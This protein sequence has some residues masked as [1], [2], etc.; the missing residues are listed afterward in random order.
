MVLIQSVKYYNYQN[1]SERTNAHSGLSLI[2]LKQGISTKNDSS[3]SFR[4]QK[5]E[6]KELKL[7]DKESGV[8]EILLNY[9][10]FFWKRSETNIQLKATKELQQITHLLFTYYIHEKLNY[11][12]DTMI[13]FLVDR[14]FKLNSD[15]LSGDHSF[16]TL[17]NY[18]ENN[19]NRPLRVS[20]FCSATHLSEA[21]VNRLCHEH[22]GTTVMRLFRKIQCWEA[23]RLMSETSLT[24]QEISTK[25]GFKD[26]KS[27]STMYR[28]NEGISPME[29]RK[30]IGGIIDG[31][32]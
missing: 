16:L 8:L 29:K 18:M 13:F 5:N 30:K 20:D 10:F 19:V 22:T 2:I 7:I 1:L 11:P 31:V 24:I 32:E 28:R 3:L 12:V 6:G 14:I 15:I 25:L 27:F 9:T 4:L 17:I 26:S 23:E 21:S